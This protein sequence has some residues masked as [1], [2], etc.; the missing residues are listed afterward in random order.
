MAQIGFYEEEKSNF[1]TFQSDNCGETEAAGA[2]CA[3]SDMRLEMA[4][5]TELSTLADLGGSYHFSLGIQ[6]GMFQSQYPALNVSISGTSVQA[7]TSSIHLCPPTIT[8]MQSGEVR[9]TPPFGTEN[10]SV[11]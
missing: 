5:V 2:L 6:L 3:I 1:I 10:I 9:L 8:N 7:N 4:V 11:L